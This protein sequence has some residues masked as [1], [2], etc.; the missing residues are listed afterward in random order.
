[1]LAS[2]I[3][4]LSGISLYAMY[5]LY[6]QQKDWVSYLLPTTGLITAGFQ[7]Y[8]MSA[9]TSEIG[10]VWMY[11]LGLL[12]LGLTIALLFLKRNHPFGKQLT[13]ISLCVLLLAPI[14]WSATSLLYGGNSVL[15]ESGP[16]LKNS[17]GGGGMFTSEVDTGRLQR[18]R[19]DFVGV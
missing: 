11:V 2:P 10:S 8:I 19:P 7:V 6:K 13:I 15:P 16:Q 18:H 14:Y 9:Y 1:M 5:H 4:A 12:G 17:S 3:A